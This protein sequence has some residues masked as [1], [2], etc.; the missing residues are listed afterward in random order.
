MST[1]EITLIIALVIAFIYG[2]GAT[3]IITESNKDDTDKDNYAASY[4]E[5]NIKNDIHVFVND[6]GKVV[7]LFMFINEYARMRERERASERSNNNTLF[8][9]GDNR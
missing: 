6:N 7:S 9:D 4:D 5:D 3:I 1:L 2:I 8:G